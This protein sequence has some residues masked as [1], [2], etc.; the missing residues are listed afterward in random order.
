[1][2]LGVAVPFECGLYIVGAEVT[3]CCDLLGKLVGNDGR[4]M[5]ESGLLGDPEEFIALR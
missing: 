5:E 3:N 1:M 2:N 4:Q